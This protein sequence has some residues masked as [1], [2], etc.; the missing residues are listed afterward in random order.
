MMIVVGF[1]ISVATVAACWW[2][3]A[4][5]MDTKQI[6]WI[7]IGFVTFLAGLNVSKAVVP[8]DPL[9]TDEKCW[10]WGGRSD[11]TWNC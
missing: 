6:R 5:Y 10:S 2:I 9:A 8:I 4:R 11:N 7:V 1:L 3:G